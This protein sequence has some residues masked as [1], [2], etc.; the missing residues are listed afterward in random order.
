MD[1]GS[2]VFLLSVA[3]A[4]LAI[5]IPPLWAAARRKRHD[6]EDA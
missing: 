3:A 1:L 4:G 6:D 2:L 5:A